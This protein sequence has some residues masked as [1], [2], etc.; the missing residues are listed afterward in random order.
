[1]TVED[2]HAMPKQRFGNKWEKQVLQARG[3]SILDICKRLGI[4]LF[5]RK[6]NELYGVCPFHDDKVANLHVQPEKAKSG[7]WYCFTCDRSGLPLQ[8]YMDVKKKTWSEAV[9]D[10]VDGN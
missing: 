5:E 7:L 1:M 4:E 3:I 9:N 8:L 6:P 2:S 10:L